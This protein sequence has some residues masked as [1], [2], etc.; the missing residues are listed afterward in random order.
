MLII[1]GVFVSGKHVFKVW[2]KF[3]KLCCIEFKKVGMQDIEEGKLLFK[4][5][6]EK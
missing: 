2:G 6:A 5:G 3:L 1:A 4:V